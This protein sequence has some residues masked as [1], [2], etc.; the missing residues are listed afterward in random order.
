M[1]PRRIPFHCLPTIVGKLRQATV[2]MTVPSVWLAK[3]CLFMKP[4]PVSPGPFQ[5]R[6]PRPLLPGRTSFEN[7]EV[8]RFGSRYVWRSFSRM[9]PSPYLPVSQLFKDRFFRTFTLRTWSSLNAFRRRFVLTA[10][11]FQVDHSE[12]VPHDSTLFLIQ[13]RSFLPK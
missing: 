7:P 1:E 9:T 12:V 8:S 13:F 4:G 5:T 2:I 11:L 10:C 6:I 3:A